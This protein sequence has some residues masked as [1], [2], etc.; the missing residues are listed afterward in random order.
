MS[1]RTFPVLPL[2]SGPERPSRWISG[3]SGTALQ[4]WAICAHP[5]IR[6]SVL[7]Q[8]TELAILN[9]NQ[10]VLGTPAEHEAIAWGMA[11]TAERVR[12]FV[13]LTIFRDEGE[14]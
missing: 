5:S 9:I 8:D 6:A 14:A 7:I 11:R 10:A 1:M 13:F 3:E 2:R 12:G 4:L